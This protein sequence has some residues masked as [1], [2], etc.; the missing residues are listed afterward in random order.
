M[1]PCRGLGSWLLLFLETL[2]RFSSK[3]RAQ[4]RS[5]SAI[6]S[7]AL[8][9]PKSR[10]RP[11]TMENPSPHPNPKLWTL[12]CLTGSAL[13]HIQRG[14]SALDFQRCEAASRQQDHSSVGAFGVLGELHL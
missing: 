12:K 6:Y 3:T 9:T 4:P 11:K 8:F 14:V 1:E 7:Q 10:T 2:C 5:G 13:F